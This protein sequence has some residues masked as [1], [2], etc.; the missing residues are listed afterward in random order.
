MIKGK[1]TFRMFAIRWLQNGIITIFIVSCHVFRDI[2]STQKVSAQ[3]GSAYHKHDSTKGRVYA[4][5]TQ[6]YV[7]PLTL[8]LTCAWNCMELRVGISIFYLFSHT[9]AIGFRVLTF[10]IYK[11]KNYEVIKRFLQKL[12]VWYKIKY[13]KLGWPCRRSLEFFAF[14]SLQRSKIF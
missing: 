5:E 7:I 8:V 11:K 14:L 2:A 12:L 1:T 3:L 10:K 13:L 9:Y 6:K 4:T